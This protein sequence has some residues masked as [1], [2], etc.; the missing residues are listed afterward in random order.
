MRTLDHM[1]HHAIHGTTTATASFPALRRRFQY[2]VSLNDIGRKRREMVSG[3][4]VSA[5]V[6][7]VDGWV[8]LRWDTTSGQCGYQ[9]HYS[10]IYM[11][12]DC[13]VPIDESDRAEC[14]VVLLVAPLFCVGSK[15]AQ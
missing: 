6:G 10:N 13:L 12:C 8:R 4:T 7:C 5:A 9:V 2:R 15:R 3:M 14:M 11:K 1:S